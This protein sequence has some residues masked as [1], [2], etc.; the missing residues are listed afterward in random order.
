MLI[1]ELFEDLSFSEMKYVE[2]IADAF[3]NKLGIEV[4]FTRHF[5]DRVNDAR[6]REP[7]TADELIELFKKEYKLYGK[8]ISSMHPDSEAVMKDIISKINLPFV[9]TT[10]GRHKDIIAKTVMRKDDF[11]TPGAI[12]K[13]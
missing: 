3:W 4:K 2:Q 1:R 10:H 9:I 13:V 8:D 6:N 12:Y 11:K 7:I 5:M